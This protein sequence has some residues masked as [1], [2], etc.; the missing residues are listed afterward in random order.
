MWPWTSPRQW[1]A[2]KC[3]QVWL[4][5][6]LFF[7]CSEAVSWDR[8]LRDHSQCCQTCLWLSGCHYIIFQDLSFENSLPSVVHFSDT[9][10]ALFAG[11]FTTRQFIVVLV[12]P[13]RWA[14][15]CNETSSTFQIRIRIFSYIFSITSS[16]VF[17]PGHIYQTSQIWCFRTLL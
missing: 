12:L 15:S 2:C 3:L 5:Y 9:S 14:I 8:S 11:A 7:F 10:R 1:N 13:S 6:P 17:T 16:C 4:F